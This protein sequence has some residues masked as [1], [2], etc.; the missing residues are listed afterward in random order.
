M[1][2]KITPKCVCGSTRF[3]AYMARELY[4]VD[5]S[6][7]RLVERVSLTEDYCDYTIH[8]KNCGLE[9]CDRG[10]IEEYEWCEEIHTQVAHE[11]Q[12]H[13]NSR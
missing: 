10:F 13:F 9:I 5:F 11:L 7:E 12:E 8:C 6:K 3:E 1:S 2:N 4:L